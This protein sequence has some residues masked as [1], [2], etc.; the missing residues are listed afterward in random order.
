MT[1]TYILKKEFPGGYKVNDKVIRK[2]NKWYW[3]R[4]DRICEYSPQIEKSFFTPFIEPVFAKDDIVKINPKFVAKYKNIN[5]KTDLTIVDVR[6]IRNKYTYTVFNGSTRIGGIEEKHLRKPKYYW[7]INSSG[8]VYKDEVED[9]YKYEFRKVTG[10]VY[11]TKEE[12]TVALDTI[13]N[14]IN[15]SFIY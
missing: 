4:T 10:N 11:D 6:T 9:S 2:G 8:A 5:V 15:N 1:N 14:E 12:A 3:E 13:K 7:F